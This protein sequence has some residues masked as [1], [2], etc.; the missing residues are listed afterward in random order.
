M[1]LTTAAEALLRAVHPVAPD[2]LGC[3][4]PPRP[5]D[6]VYLEHAPLMR[7]VVIRKFHVPSA[8][9]DALVHDVFVAYLANPQRVRTNLKAYLVTG[10]C[11]AARK[12]WRSKS[13]D[14]RL[15][16][17]DPA[18]DDAASADDAFADLARNLTVAATLAQLGPRCQEALRRYYLD[19]EDTSTIA[20]ALNTSPGNVNYIMYTC[21]LRA[22]EIHEEMSR[23]ADARRSSR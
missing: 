6:E 15:F 10:A 13:Y 9:A 3:P 20:A 17:E 1:D 18:T 7:R 16:T 5:F 22:R 23:S 8:D 11:N 4:P 14:E 19:G 21:R 12:Y 2:A